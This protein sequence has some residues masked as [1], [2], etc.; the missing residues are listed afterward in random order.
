MRRR[1]F[2]AGLGGAVAWPL[3]ARAQQ[4]D[5]M[6]RV[7]VL[8]S[9]D[10]TDPEGKARLSGFLQG[11][12]ELGWTEGRNVRLDI[13]WAGENVDRI[14]MFATELVGMTPDVVL[15]GG[16]APLLALQ[17]ATQT[18]PIVF[19]VVPDPVAN[20][21]V[22]SVARPSGNITGF[23]TY[24]NTIG[25]KWL[26]LLTEIAP[27]VT[28]VAFMYDPANP[29]SPGYL[30]E[31]EAAAP[32]LGMQVSGQAVHNTAEIERVLDAHASALNGGLVVLASP[33]VDANRKQ[34][35]ALAAKHRLPAIYHFRVYVADGG[36]ASYGADPV[37]LFRRAATYVDRILK[38]DKPSVL[39]VQFATKF[40]LVINLKTARA[41]GLTVPETLLVRADEVIE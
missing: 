35:I 11:L 4:P 1:E 30:R 39:P 27:R 17:K 20:G 24:E 28:R 16:A 14:R 5:R 9:F 3:A 25:A 23:A 12:A 38:G 31:S 10:E 36:L 37:D 33:I 21:F 40:E 2:I 18:M 29:I 8:M 26:E 15:A 19:A 22:A 7:G 34:I 41:L 6:R 32:S 13:R